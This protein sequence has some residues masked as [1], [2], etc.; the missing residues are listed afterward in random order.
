MAKAVDNK[1][2]LATLPTLKSVKAINAY[3]DKATEGWTKNDF[4]QGAKAIKDALNNAQIEVNPDLFVDYSPRTF[5]NDGKLVTPSKKPPVYAGLAFMWEKAN[6]SA[7]SQKSTRTRTRK[8]PRKTEVKANKKQNHLDTLALYNLCKEFIS[9]PI[10][11]DENVW[12]R[13][14]IACCFFTGRRIFEVLEAMDFSPAGLHLMNVK[15]IL[16]TKTRSKSAMIPVLYDSELIVQAIQEIRVYLSTHRS[17]A[18]QEYQAEGGINNS[19]AVWKLARNI[20]RAVLREHDKGAR[21]ILM[22]CA[23]EDEE[24]EAI[25]GLRR[26]YAATML[27]LR[28]ALGSPM[29]GKQELNFV[30]D[31]LAHEEAQTS[32][33]YLEFIPA[34]VDELAAVLGKPFKMDIE[35]GL[36]RTSTAAKARKFL[37]PL[38]LDA[39]AS[40]EE[41]TNFESILESSEPDSGRLELT[42]ARSLN[43]KVETTQ[44]KSRK[45]VE[46]RVSGEDRARTIVECLLDWNPDALPSK[47]IFI[48]AGIVRKISKQHSTEIAPTV[49]KRVIDELENAITEQNDLLELDKSTNDGHRGKLEALLQQFIDKY[50][51]RL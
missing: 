4:S 46:E 11:A 27:K 2:I 8:T 6:D 51:A 10:T 23:E 37:Y 28:N 40:D 48:S 35:Y 38:F 5:E 39:L 24:K 25:H 33:E 43:A 30:R 45:T 31:A 36:K 18:M 12:K 26:A 34:K 17:D 22:G 14:A 32:L 50:N 19:Q 20:T 29:S 47:K 16:K 13:K 7:E 21:N 49:V 41:R 3:L 15:G 9:E 1:A 42:L 44:P